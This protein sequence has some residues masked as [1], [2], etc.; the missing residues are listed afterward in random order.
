Q[1]WG[2]AGAAIWSQPA[3]DLKRNRLYV[4]T[5]DSYTEVD[6]DGADA[7]AALDLTSG[8]IVWMNQVTEADNFLTACFGERKGINC[9]LG[10]IGPDVDFGASPIL[11]TAPGGKQVV[12]SGQKSGVAYAMDPDTGRKLW[13]VKLG[14]GSPS[15]GVEWGMTYDGRRLF[16]PIAD[17]SVRKDPHPGLYALDPLTGAL[18]WSAPAPPPACSFKSQRC[19]NSHSAP[20]SAMP[21]AVFAGTHDGWL[22]AFD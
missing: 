9:P 11:A 18:V 22:R 14:A 12:L 5:G 15:G 17:G 7:I 1:R 13:A 4:A 20:A 6:T 16:V 3:L 19:V 2:P 10:A 8:H 21:G